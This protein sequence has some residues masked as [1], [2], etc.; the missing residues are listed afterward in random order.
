MGSDG[1]S[2][3]VTLQSLS[4][5]LEELKKA[6][7]KVMERAIY[8]GMTTAEAQDIDDRRR[9]IYALYEMIFAMGRAAHS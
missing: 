4:E 2:P 7:D 8:L 9:R 3:K 5:E 1:T 6:Q